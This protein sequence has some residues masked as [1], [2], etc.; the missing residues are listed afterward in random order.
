MDIKPLF[1]AFACEPELG[2]EPRIGWNCVYQASR[3]RPVWVITDA[4]HRNSIEAHL[5]GKEEPN[6][7]VVYYAPIRIG[8]WIWRRPFMLNIY[9]YLW[10]RGAAKLARKLHEEHHF[11]VV[12]HVSYIR[13]WMPSAAGFIGIPFVWGPVGGGESAP[14]GFLR[15]SSIRACAEEVMRSA[16]RWLFEQDPALRKCAQTADVGIASSFESAARMKRLRVKKLMTLSCIGI[17]PGQTVPALD[18]P[19][20]AKV[21]FISVGRLLYWKGFQFG[22][23]AFAKANLPDAEYVIVGAGPEL[24]NLQSLAARLGIEDRVKFTGQLPLRDGLEQFKQADVLVHPSLH[25][26]GGMVLLEAMELAKPVICLE[27]GGPALLVDSRNGFAIPAIS[28]SQV[29]EETAQAMVQLASD[30]DLRKRLGEAGRHRA[31]SEF[32]WESKTKQF[33]E[34]YRKIIRRSKQQDLAA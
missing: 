2:S 10:H 3:T 12:H 23:R 4:L 29:I 25:D 15:G 11:D 24:K 7:N 33:E 8:Q 14:S 13:Y 1:I 20:D 30:P 26:S 31:I 6:I 18:R 19:A 22:L 32:S 27:V 9:Y 34:I 5:A 28:V 17:I 16:M 21:R